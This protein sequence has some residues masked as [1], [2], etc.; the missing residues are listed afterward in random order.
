MTFR[1]N[2]KRPKNVNYKPSLKKKHCYKDLG[3]SMRP[4]INNIADKMM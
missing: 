3:L 4:Y 1:L 2:Y